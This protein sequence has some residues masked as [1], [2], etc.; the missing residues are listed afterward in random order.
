MVA[1]SFNHCRS[2]CFWVIL[3][4]IDGVLIDLYIDEN[5]TILCAGSRYKGRVRRL[6]IL[7][8]LILKLAT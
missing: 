3:S 5:M 4:C 8:V 6:D 2:P 7:C 1:A